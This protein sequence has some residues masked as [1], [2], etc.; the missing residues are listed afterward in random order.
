MTTLQQTC[1]SF[2]IPLFHYEAKSSLV[3][4]S[5]K[6]GLSLSAEMES[7]YELDASDK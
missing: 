5:W 3:E 1:E 2:V 7:F 4:C 6:G